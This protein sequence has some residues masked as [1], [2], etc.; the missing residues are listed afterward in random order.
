MLML[1]CHNSWYEVHCMKSKK[2]TGE[3]LN[4]ISAKKVSKPQF[5]F[6]L[7]S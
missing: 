4:V 1:F 3:L 7:S 6:T 5:A 2:L